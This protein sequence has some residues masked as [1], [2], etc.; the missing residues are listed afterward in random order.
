MIKGNNK[1]KQ[2]IDAFFTSKWS[3]YLILI[4]TSFIVLPN[5]SRES[6]W[7][8]ELFT[9]NC[10][11]E[12]S[13]IHSMFTEYIFKDVHP[14]LYQLMLYYWGK[15]IG[16]SDFD[17]R[18]LS[19]LAILVS[20]IFSYLLLKKY[21]TKRIAILFIAL[22]A[23]TPG[24]MY[25]AQEARPYA[26]LYGLSNLLIVIFVI[27]MIN[28]KQNKNIQNSLVFAYFILGILTC[29]AHFFGYIL[30]FS[31]SMILVG[32]SIVLHSRK[33]TFKLF[34]VS[35]FIAIMGILWLLVLFY[36]GNIADKTN[37]NFW[38]KNNY[39]GDLLGIE[40]ML[41]SGIKTT[42]IEIILLFLLVIPFN[43]F[44]N[45]F[46][47]N[48]LILLP[49]LLIFVVSILISLHTPI[50]TSRNLIIIFPSFLLFIAFT[51]DDLYD[52]KKV[53]ILLYIIVLFVSSSYMS[54]TYKKQDWR[55]ASK[56]IEKNFD[57]SKCKIPTRSGIDAS[58]GQNFL[59]YPSYYLKSKF[60]YLTNGPEV[61]STCSLI[62]FDGHTNEENIKK[63]LEE[64][65]IAVPYKILNFNGVYVVIKK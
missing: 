54:F 33:T 46:K 9:A 1:A 47:R 6:L 18:F 50:I 11:L 12:V 13:S 64:N 45:T 56:Y 23:F 16:T 51:F 61:Q 10:S 19:Y 8:D 53:F 30:I 60:S 36:Y 14:P 35:L 38:I 27:F 3:I 4:A 63:S 41:F 62:Y 65:H 58:T 26:I 43:T 32:Y 25:Y 48:S 29:Y 49:I 15:I 44:A 42:A 40:R 59:I 28:I 5:I 24:I 20:F 31:L 2:W 22:S 39:F 17:I 57:T 7:F 52:K 34:I 37:G 55:G 21:F